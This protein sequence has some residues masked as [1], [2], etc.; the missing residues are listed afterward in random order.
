MSVRNWLA[1]ITIIIIYQ[2]KAI[3]IRI[4]SFLL[5]LMACFICF[6]KAVIFTDA[7]DVPMF[8]SGSKT[9]QRKGIA[10]CLSK[11]V[12]IH[13]LLEASNFCN[14][15][16]WMS[17]VVFIQ[18]CPA[19]CFVLLLPGSWTLTF[20]FFFFFFFKKKNS[21]QIPTSPLLTLPLTPSYSEQE[22]TLFICTSLY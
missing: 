20:K 9:A 14:M 3:I 17:I 11:Y 7:L 13:Q 12:L 1:P 2:N 22:I 8:S 16:V 18:A 5:P 10:V 4:S 15:C 21:F 19:F 6:I